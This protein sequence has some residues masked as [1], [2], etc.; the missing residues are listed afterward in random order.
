MEVPI[1]SQSAPRSPAR[2]LA[3]NWLVATVTCRSCVG[4]STNGS[5][6]SQR[7]EAAAGMKC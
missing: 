5:A 3:V 4:E 7:S 2:R 1:I 6:G